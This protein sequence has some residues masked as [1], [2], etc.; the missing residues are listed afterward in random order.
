MITQATQPYILADK[1]LRPK[2]AI[3]KP[4][5]VPPPETFN[6]I[7]ANLDIF[8]NALIDFENMVPCLNLLSYKGAELPSPLG[9]SAL[10]FCILPN[11]D[12]LAYWDLA[13]DR[14][15]KIRNCENIK[16]RC[17]ASSALLSTDR[18]RRTGSKRLRKVLVP[19][20]LLRTCGT[21]PLY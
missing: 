10:Y 15:F 7:E 20:S 2:P 12:M 13:A 14:L 3:V 8:G 6:Q 18:S 5:A 1:L 17:H 19:P 16:L 21:A 11:I 9:Y 4:A